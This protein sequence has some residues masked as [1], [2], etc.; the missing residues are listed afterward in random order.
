VQLALDGQKVAARFSNAEKTLAQADIVLKGAAGRFG[1][2]TDSG[3]P[4]GDW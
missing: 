3:H 4:P 1:G 2:I